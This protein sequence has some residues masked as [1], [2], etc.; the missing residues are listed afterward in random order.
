MVQLNVLHILRVLPTNTFAT[1]FGMNS[2]VHTPLR[3][4]IFKHTAIALG[5]VSR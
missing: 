3:F 5:P 4:I 1:R 2:A